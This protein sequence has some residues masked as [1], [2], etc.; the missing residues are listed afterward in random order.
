MVRLFVCFCGRVGWGCLGEG[1]GTYTAEEMPDEDDQDPSRSMLVVRV[2]TL[3]RMPPAV[4]IQHEHIRRF[5]QIALGRWVVVHRDVAVEIAR[6]PF[7]PGWLHAAHS[8]A[9]PDRRRGHETEE[10]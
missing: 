9:R 5:F 7:W 4:L 8:A 6:R 2:E 10:E 1:G 3:E